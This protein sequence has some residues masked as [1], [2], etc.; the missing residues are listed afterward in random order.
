LQAFKRTVGARIV[1]LS[2][3]LLGRRLLRLDAGYCAGAGLIA[4]GAAAP[5]ARLLETPR[6]V[7]LAAGAATVVWAV[8]LARIAGWADWRRP[9]AA[10]AAAN[11]LGA[12]GIAVLVVFS[13][14]A[15][16]KL[17]LAAVAVEVAAF[18]VGQA[19]ALR[20]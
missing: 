18:A 5:L 20:R 14:G 4:L 13:P 1:P 16:A 12:S 10:V 19:A 2:G 9:V 17:L 6:A 11:T 15:A 3:E 8:V 7:P